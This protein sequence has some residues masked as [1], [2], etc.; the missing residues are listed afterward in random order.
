[1]RWAAG[2]SV[3]A[4]VLH[5]I[6][7]G[8]HFAEWWAYGVIFFVASLAQGVYGFVIAA[9]HVMNGAPISET[10]PRIAWRAWS[11]VGSAAN[12]LLVALYVASRT[13]GVLGEREA[14][15]PLG[16]LT[17]LVELALVAVLAALYRQTS[18]ARP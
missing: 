4:G 1:M 18:L 3:A 5:G 11:F 6:A 16:V 9:S 15:E 7:A 2:L 14:W 8:A 17:A 13:V 10:W 12:L